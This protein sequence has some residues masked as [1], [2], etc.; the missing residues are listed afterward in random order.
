VFEAGVPG[1]T[2]AIGG[3]AERTNLAHRPRHLRRARSPRPAADGRPARRRDPLRARI[4]PATTAATRSTPAHIRT[5][6]GWEPQ[7]ALEDGIEAT[8]RW[9][10]DHP[11]WWQDILAS[12]RAT[13]RLGLGQT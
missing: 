3:N 11:G 13:D 4:A 9:Y 6:L 5:T 8:V 7:H 12:H 1:Q 10:I 2:Y